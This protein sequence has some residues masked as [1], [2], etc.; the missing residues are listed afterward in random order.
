[1]KIYSNVEKDTLLHIISKA[2]DIV[3]ER[4]DITPVNYFL[5]VGAM[6]LNNNRTFDRHYHIK[7]ERHTDE[8]HE[9]WIVIKGKIKAIL[10]DL[11]NTLIHEEILGPGDCVIT[12]KGGHN[13]LCLEDNT[14]AYEFKNG[15]YKGNKADKELF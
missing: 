15:P 2:D 4:H 8:T 12:V 6:R 11:D 13:W 3:N 1:M 10:Y 9:S 5:Q 7:N 14:L